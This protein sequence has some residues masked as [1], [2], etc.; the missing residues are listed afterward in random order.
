MSKLRR[1]HLLLKLLSEAL[2]LVS[3]TILLLL[4]AAVNASDQSVTCVW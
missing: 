1:S 2:H 3:Y 4:A